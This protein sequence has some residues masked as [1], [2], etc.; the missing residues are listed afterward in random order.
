MPEE[1]L[2]YAYGCRSNNTMEAHGFAGIDE[3]KRCL[4]TLIDRG[5]KFCGV[6]PTPVTGEQFRKPSVQPASVKGKK[7]K[8]SK[9]WKKKN[10]PINVKLIGPQAN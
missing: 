5:L 9:A 7:R 3:A 2:Y 10:R 6:T 4:A 8:K 1:P